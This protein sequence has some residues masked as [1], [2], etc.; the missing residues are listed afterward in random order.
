MLPLAASLNFRMFFTNHPET[1]LFLISIYNHFKCSDNNVNPSLTHLSGFL[2]LNVA[3][4]DFSL[5]STW[6]N[7]VWFVLIIIAVIEKETSQMNMSWLDTLSWKPVSKTASLHPF[8]WVQSSDKIRECIIKPHCIYDTSHGH[9][10]DHFEVTALERRRRVD[11]AVRCMRCWPLSER[12]RKS[13]R[14]RGR[15]AM[16]RA[17]GSSPGRLS[18]ARQSL[19]RGCLQTACATQTLPARDPVTDAWA[20]HC[21][22]LLKSFSQ[23]KRCWFD[24]LKTVHFIIIR[25]VHK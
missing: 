24:F 25:F 12:G 11:G 7:T 5:E 18:V 20:R 16:R 22:W 4:R 10:A 8:S 6:Q 13:C 1:I 2:T 14:W 21:W 9:V 15:G 19:G 23:K 3:F 17:A